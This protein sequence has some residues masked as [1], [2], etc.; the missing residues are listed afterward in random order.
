MK[1][2]TKTTMV[3]LALLASTTFY[4]NAKE[5]AS[6][7]RKVFI[8]T[9]ENGTYK[10]TYLK[11]GACNVQVKILDEVGNEVYS[12]KI[13]SAKSFTK[14]YS[15]EKL[16]SG[17]YTFKI[18]DGAGTVMKT[19]ALSNGPKIISADIRKEDNQQ[20]E[21]IVKGD[22]LSPVYVN[23]YDRNNVLIYGDKIDHTKSFSRKYDLSKLNTSELKFEVINNGDLIATKKF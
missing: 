14:P 22:K 9:V 20:Y 1:K 7:E 10:L 3:V 18:E 21:L 16:Q 13:Q 23:I 19:V 4:A 17:T 6:T 15:L 2:L 5:G 8:K 11:D 12:E